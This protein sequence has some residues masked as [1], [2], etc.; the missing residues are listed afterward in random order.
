MLPFQSLSQGSASE[1]RQT[2]TKCSG[3]RT[4]LI[5]ED[6]RDSEQRREPSR[7][8]VEGAACAKVPGG[9]RL[10]GN[11]KCPVRLESGEQ[12]GE[13]RVSVQLDSRFL[14][15]QEKEPVLRTLL[16]AVNPSPQVQK[17]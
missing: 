11:E 8:Q 5:S 7:F 17:A 6:D 13:L 3:G 2:K 4:E 14:Y 15:W 12:T 10:V 9:R 1:K 16:A